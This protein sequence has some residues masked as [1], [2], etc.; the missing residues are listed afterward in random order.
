MLTPSNT[1]KNSRLY[2]TLVAHLTLHHLNNSITTYFDS[3]I[4]KIICLLHAMARSSHSQSQ[5]GPAVCSPTTQ[6]AEQP[7]LLQHPLLVVVGVLLL[8][9]VVMEQQLRTPHQRLHQAV[10]SQVQYAHFISAYISQV[11]LKAGTIKWYCSLSVRF[12]KLHS[13]HVCQ[14]HV[15]AK[16]TLETHH[17]SAKPILETRWHL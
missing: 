1:L 17:F 15:S 6:P 5:H 16:P 13:R 2:Q 8:L 14:S 10:Q 9:A 3:L 7:T 11:Q 4:A 12:A